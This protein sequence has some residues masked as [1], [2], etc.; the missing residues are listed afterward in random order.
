VQIDS[1]HGNVVH[2]D[3]VHGDEL[4]APVVVDN[5]TC[6]GCAHVADG[7]IT[8]QQQCHN[9]VTAAT[10]LSTFVTSS[11]TLTSEDGHSPVKL[12]AGHVADIDDVVY[13]ELPSPQHRSSTADELACLDQ[14]THLKTTLDRCS[15]TSDISSSHIAVDEML[16]RFPLADTGRLSGLLTVDTRL[17]A[18]QSQQSGASATVDTDGSSSQT[19]S[20]SSTSPPT[21]N[22]DSKVLCH[23]NILLHF[24]LS[25]VLRE[26]V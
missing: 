6:N 16:S 11:D 9:G 3:V 7:D 17:A 23:L 12:D 26:N 2:N 4:L 15:S 20:R 10:L 21:P 19:P 5:N 13:D 25:V 24:A 22:G 8:C 18:N 14:N 1:L